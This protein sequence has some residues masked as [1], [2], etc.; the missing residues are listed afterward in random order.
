[1]DEPIEREAPL[2]SPLRTMT[3]RGKVSLLM[4]EYGNWCIG[5]IGDEILQDQR[6][7]SPT[8]NM[9]RVLDQQFFTQQ[10]TAFAHHVLS[11]EWTRKGKLNWF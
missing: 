4:R 11:E 6:A 8:K 1:M 7:M 2:Q 10:H 9:F 3:R 5:R